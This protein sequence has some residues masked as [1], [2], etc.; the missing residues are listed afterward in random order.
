MGFEGL[1]VDE[2]K[3]ARNSEFKAPAYMQ[4]TIDSWAQKGTYLMIVV[5]AVP[6]APGQCRLLNRQVAY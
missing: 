6:I 5:Y 1:N 4:H 3:G 2:T